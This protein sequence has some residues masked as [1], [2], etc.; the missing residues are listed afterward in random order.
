VAGR[1]R[2]AEAGDLAA[3]IDEGVARISRALRT[4]V[5]EE[6][7]SLP[8]PL[9]APQVQVLEILVAH[10]RTADPGMSLTQ[11]SERMHL[12]H[13]TVSG[14]V[15]RLERRGLVTRAPSASDRRSIAI[16]LSADVHAWLET[17]PA[18]ARRRR[19]EAALARVA[20]AEATRLARAIE[21]LS[22]LLEDTGSARRGA[23]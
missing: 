23:G 1:R 10:E 20:P 19:V 7:G 21:R 8:D 18:A 9:T 12:A 16:R 11:L 13:S 3:A 5:R 15:M 6:A 14:I 2:P 17:G 4:A 22:V